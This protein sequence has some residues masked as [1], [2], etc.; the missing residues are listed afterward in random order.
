M[1]TQCIYYTAGATCGRQVSVTPRLA[2]VE[3]SA[4]R[5]STSLVMTAVL[6]IPCA[7]LQL[8]RRAE[9]VVHVLLPLLELISCS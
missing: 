5:H 3:K 9:L 7:V 6:Y 1:L 4:V 8:Q 2:W